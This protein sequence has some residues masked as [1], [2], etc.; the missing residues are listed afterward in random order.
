MEGL[1]K[2]FEE[3]LLDPEQSTCDLVL[4]SV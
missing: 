3:K 4:I 1:E 2:Y